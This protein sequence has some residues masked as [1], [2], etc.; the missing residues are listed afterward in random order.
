MTRQNFTPLEDAALSRIHH[1]D[2]TINC[3]AISKPSE[4][5]SQLCSCQFHRADYNSLMK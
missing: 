3:F 2:H 5:L 4:C 1:Q